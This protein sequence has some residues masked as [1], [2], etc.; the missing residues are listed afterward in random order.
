MTCAVKKFKGLLTDQWKKE[1]HQQGLF[2][3]VVDLLVAVKSKG[4][5][6]WV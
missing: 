3:E 6:L 4:W 2:E 1:M 5:G